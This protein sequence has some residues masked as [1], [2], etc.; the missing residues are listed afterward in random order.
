[1]KRII[2]IMLVVFL[3]GSCCGCG[4]KK[5]G[6]NTNSS[7]SGDSSVVDSGNSSV[8]DDTTEITDDG[9]GYYGSSG[10]GSAGGQ[11][12]LAGNDIDFDYIDTEDEDEEEE[13]APKVK[14]K[15]VATLNTNWKGDAKYTTSVSDEQAK[16]LRNKVLNAKNTA[17]IYK[18]QITGTIYYVSQNG[19]NNNKGTSPEE[20]FYDT[21]ADVFTRNI[22]KEGD[23]VLFERG[24]VWRVT[25]TIRTRPGVI[26]GAYGKGNKPSFYASSKNY[27][28]PSEWTPSNLK[29]VWKLTVADPDIGLIV[30][31]H[32]EM[33]GVKKGNGLIALE[34]NGDYFYNNAQHVV[35]FYYDKGNPGRKF[36]DIEVGLK[37]NIFGLQSGSIIDNICMKYSGAF[38]ISA[39]ACY[40]SA[41]TNCE[42]GFIGGAYQ[43]QKDKTRYGNGI[44]VWNGVINHLI[45]DNWIYQIYDTGATWQ[46][47]WNDPAGHTDHTFKNISYDSNL[48]EY[49]AMSME[50]WYDAE[51]PTSAQYE[52]CT[53]TNNIS[54]F[55]GF[56]FSKQ[57][58]DKKG[59][60]IYIGTREFPNAV[61]CAITGNIFDLAWTCMVDWRPNSLSKIGSWNIEKNSWYQ[62]ATDDSTVMQFG[63]PYKATN[64]AELET[65]VKILDKDPKEIKWI[66]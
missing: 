33:V 14:E 22:L 61:E 30:F 60:H 38:R 35:Y 10:S 3:I 66:S 7:S 20:A 11:I 45:Q 34:K 9:T 24:W 64:V 65:A 21:D 56:G 27:A 37:M 19:D 17:E 59:Q 63:N 58:S 1:M 13:E 46:G 52:K 55:A 16:A 23:A 40:D 44:Q 26:Y 36:K 48:F 32:G 47:K 51:Q 12:E 5:P 49:C 18:K 6:R 39:R 8:I 50:F 29:N 28:D 43:D 41:V 62:C 25:T 57:R 4:K 53:F 31:D 42:I 15:S 2:A 54:R